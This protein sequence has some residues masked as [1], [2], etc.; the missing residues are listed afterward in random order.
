MALEIGS[1]SKT[2]NMTGWRIGFAVGRKELVGGL[3]KVKSN[4]DSG[5]F[6]PIQL[7]A[8]YALN[9]AEE[10]TAPIRAV[11]ERRR[12]VL[13]EALSAAGLEYR[14]PQAS[15]YFW[16][17][18]PRTMSSESFAEMLI[19][20]AHIVATPG[21]GFGPSGEGYIRFTLCAP[22]ERLTEAGERIVE[23]LR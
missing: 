15:F 8:A 3:A 1:L 14:M 16:V 21:S 10:L 12:G 7:A 2:F 9:H 18:V 22:E 11:Y 6:Q 19:S 4:M 20:K 17:K 5:I 13:A 23:A